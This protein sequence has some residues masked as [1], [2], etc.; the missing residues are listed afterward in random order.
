MGVVMVELAL[1]GA[2]ALTGGYSGCTPAN[3]TDTDDA[4]CGVL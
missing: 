1:L 4:G 3:I 2:A